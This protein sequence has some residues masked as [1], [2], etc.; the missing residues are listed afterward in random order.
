MSGNIE[1]HDMAY[2]YGPRMYSTFMYLYG[3]VDSTH[4]AEACVGCLLGY[5]GWLPEGHVGQW[6]LEG[7]GHLQPAIIPVQGQLQGKSAGRGVQLYHLCS[8]EPGH[9]C[10]CSQP[11]SGR[12]RPCHAAEGQLHAAPRSPGLTPEHVSLPCTTNVQE[13]PPCFLYFCCCCW[14]SSYSPVP[15]MFV[16]ACM[17]RPTTLRWA[18]SPAVLNINQNMHLSNA[19]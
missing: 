12:P 13:L 9:A 15:E 11:H 16:Q 1:E 7:S 8:Q 3:L 19:Q 18:V 14:Q 6:H 17:T 2:H 4:S 5:P 10:P